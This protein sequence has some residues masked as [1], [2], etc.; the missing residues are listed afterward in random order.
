MTHA[1]L[2][3]ELAGAWVWRQPGSGVWYNTGRTIVFP[4]PKTTINAP[5]SQAHQAG[6]GK[7]LRCVAEKFHASQKR[8]SLSH[9]VQ[10]F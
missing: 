3:T 6:Q 1:V 10:A 2:P 9:S 7:V 5:P 8:L 4:T